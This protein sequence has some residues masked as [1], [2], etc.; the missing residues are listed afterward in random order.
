MFLVMAMGVEF[1]NI[2]E[3]LEKGNGR[4]TLPE[5]SGI[6]VRLDTDGSIFWAVDPPIYV[7][8]KD[9]N[10]ILTGTDYKRNDWM[11][12]ITRETTQV[13]DDNFTSKVWKIYYELCSQAADAGYSQEMIEQMITRPDKPYVHVKKPSTKQKQ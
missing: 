4:A 12:Y 13:K 11:P 9:Y 7:T 8:C 6:F 3:A 1:M 2:F 5:H 10:S